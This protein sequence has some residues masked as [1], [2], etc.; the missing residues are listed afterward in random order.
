MK[1]SVFV[2]IVAFLHLNVFSQITSSLQILDAQPYGIRKFYSVYRNI[3]YNKFVFVQLGIYF[4]PGWTPNE[5]GKILRYDNNR[6]AW[7]VPFNGF[8]NTYWCY[9]GFPPNQ[10]WHYNY[11]TQFAMSPADT[12]FVI[13]NW[14]QYCG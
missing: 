11:I 2:A 14:N 8:L 4:Q 6:L 5:T 10:Q 9:G 13:K 3:N 12:Q 7:Y 1:K